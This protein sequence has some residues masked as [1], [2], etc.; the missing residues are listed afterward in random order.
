MKYK[1]VMR[2]PHKSSAVKKMRTTHYRKLATRARQ[3]NWTIFKNLRLLY[4]MTQKCLVP[5]L[6]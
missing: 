4:M 6:E 5:H 3:N 2:K 1:S